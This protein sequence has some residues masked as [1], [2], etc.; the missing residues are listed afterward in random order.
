MSRCLEDLSR[1]LYR[2]LR[3]TFP[4]SWQNVMESPTCNIRRFDSPT[5][6]I[7]LLTLG[8]AAQFVMIVPV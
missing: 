5:V 1:I 7:K 8:D 3:E 2:D 6:L 4:A